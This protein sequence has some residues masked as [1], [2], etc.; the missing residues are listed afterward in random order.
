MVDGTAVAGC[1]NWY[2]NQEPATS[3]PATLSELPASSK[4]TTPDK[5]PGQVRNRSHP[6]F[7]TFFLTSDI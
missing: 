4:A 1:C 7:L 3:N 6:L 5:T 2:L